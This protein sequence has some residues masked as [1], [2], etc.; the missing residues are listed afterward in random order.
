MRLHLRFS[1][2][3]SLTQARPKSTKKIGDNCHPEAAESL[4]HER[5]PTKD[6]CN[7]LTIKYAPC[8]NNRARGVPPSFASYAKGGKR[9]SRSTTGNA[10]SGVNEFYK[11]ECQ[12]KSSPSTGGREDFGSRDP[13]HFTVRVPLD[14]ARGFASELPSIP[15]AFI[16]RW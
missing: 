10:E 3:Y 6:L 16:V 12:E 14:C 8:K 7:S 1:G 13:A 11:K 9:E 2:S 15:V 4:A 5:L